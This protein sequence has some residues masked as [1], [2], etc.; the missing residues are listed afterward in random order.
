MLA[1][2]I[3]ENESCLE[4]LLMYVSWTV[5]DVC[6]CRIIIVP[7]IAYESLTPQLSKLSGIPNHPENQRTGA[8]GA[9]APR[10]HAVRGSQSL[11]VG[12]LNIQKYIHTTWC[13]WINLHL[14]FWKLSQGKTIVTIYFWRH[15]Y[16]GSALISPWKWISS[17]SHATAEVN[18]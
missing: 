16:H 1:Y 10:R 8:C 2:A 15:I 13:V 11:M 14:K 6:Y 17:H 18:T 3:R 12:S 9:Y 4:W 7:V 5:I